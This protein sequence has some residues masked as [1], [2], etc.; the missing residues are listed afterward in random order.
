MK[1]WFNITTHEVEAHESADRDR[2]EN[3]LGPYE[4]RSEAQ[5]AL[6]RARARTE[7]WE[8]QEEAERAAEMEWGTGLRGA[9]GLPQ[10]PDE[11]GPRASS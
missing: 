4:S 10:E 11:T 2:S 9:L 7:A 5:A 1:Y 6:D 3:L 8:E